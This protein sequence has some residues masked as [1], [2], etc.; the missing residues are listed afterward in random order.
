MEGLPPL[1]QFLARLDALDKKMSEPDFYNDQRSAS[2]LSREH[3]QLAKLKESYLE[4]EKVLSQID[5]NK[6]IIE[7]NADPEF[8]ELAKED[9]AS[10]EAKKEPLKTEILKMMIPP[11]PTDSRNTV[12]EIR[13]GTGGDEAS[14]FAADLYR[15]YCRYA[16]SRGWKVENLSSSESPAGGFK[17]ICFLLSGDDVYRFM[18]Y[19]SGTHRVQRV[20]VTEASGRIHT[21]AATV[22]VLPE[23]EE[24]EV[25]YNDKDFKIDTYRSGGAGGQHVNKTESAV[26][27]THLPTGIVVECQD[28]RSQIKNRE[29]AWKVMNSRLYDFYRSQRDKEYA[30]NRKTQV[31]TGDRSE[32]IRTYNYPQ[33]RVSD[34]RIGLT[35]YN[36]PEFL[37]GDM[38]EMVEALALAD[39]N[40]KL[41]KISD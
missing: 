17:E 36:L 35:L 18:K 2:A 20:P 39:Q 3:Q 1:E 8:V 28:E 9:L 23:A 38:F 10:L 24:V 33:G 30:D 21:S 15:M 22:A 25:E 11:D 41:S 40:A 5:E 7:E 13:A 31:G 34:H 16:D 19:E 6:K 12:V 29:K 4:F 27:I 26:R 37:D 14:L 32:R